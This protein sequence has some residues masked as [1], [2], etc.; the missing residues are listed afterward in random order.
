MDL[1]KNPGTE[2]F[3][4]EMERKIKDLVEEVY[5][6]ATGRTYKVKVANEKMIQAIRG[7]TLMEV[8]D[9]PS[10]RYQWIRAYDAVY[11]GNTFKTVLTNG[12]FMDRALDAGEVAEKVKWQGKPAINKVIS[13]IQD[14]SL[15]NISE[16]LGGGQKVRN[17]Y[18]NILVP[19]SD[20]Y[21][22][23]D[24]HAGAAAHLM[25]FGSE[26]QEIK[27][28][29]DQISLKAGAGI[30]KHHISRAIYPV[31]AEA[32]RLAAEELDMLPRE[33]QSITWEAIRGMF[34]DFLKKERNLEK[35]AL[36][37]E[38][39]KAFRAAQAEIIGYSAK[40]GKLK[41]PLDSGAAIASKGIW[42][43]LK[44]YFI[45]THRGEISDGARAGIKQYSKGYF[46]TRKEGLRSVEQF[47]PPPWLSRDPNSYDEVWVPF[48]ASGVRGVGVGGGDALERS[49]GGDVG[50]RAGRAAGKRGRGVKA[51]AQEGEGI[52]AAVRFLEDGRARIQLMRSAN[53]SSLIHEMAHVFRR[54]LSDMEQETLAKV[55]R[56]E[57]GNWSEEAEEQFARNFERYLFNGGQGFPGKPGELFERMKQTM[58]RVYQDVEKSPIG[59]QVSPEV[60][61]VFGRMF[62]EGYHSAD[63]LLLDGND[64]STRVTWQAGW[65][66][67]GI[68]VSAERVGK[69]LT[70]AEAR[71]L[72]HR[73]GVT[74]KGFTDT[75][76]ALAF[77]RDAHKT[78]GMTDKAY[79][80]DAEEKLLA[81]LK[82]D[83]AV[84][85]GAKLDPM[86][87]AQLKAEARGTA[88]TGWDRVGS[89]ASK[90]LKVAGDNPLT[91]LNRTVGRTLEDVDH[92]ALF[93]HALDEGGKG[94]DPLA[95][96]QLVK[97]YLFDATNLT[98]VEK[99]LMRRVIPFYSWLRFNI[100]L[101]LHAL[102]N[103]PGRYA[104]VPKVINEIQAQSPDWEDLPTPD[105]FDE[106]NAVRL[107]FM[108]DGKPLYLNTGLP[109][110][111]L[112]KV[113][114]PGHAKEAMRDLMSA[115]G[116]AVKGVYGLFSNQD[117]YFNRPIENYPGEVSPDVPALDK[118]TD[119]LLGVAAPAYQRAKGNIKAAERG[120]AGPYFLGQLGIKFIPSDIQRVMRGQTYS[121]L[122][123]AKAMRDKVESQNKRRRE[124]EE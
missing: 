69:P 56:T 112:N 65:K 87:I 47:N 20:R 53:P 80:R 67:L 83:E 62:G 39:Y 7:K 37:A 58:G 75:E 74:G 35:L 81:A 33:L 79:R 85:G 25:P 38:E 8:M 2:R 64:L 119:W 120:E 43:V 34:P 110:L 115:A 70:V 88:A 90:A 30:D 124:E 57:H 86:T 19:N 114:L 104:M 103:D 27:A 9:D 76:T 12:K 54:Q 78:L 94:A 123:I 49:A 113:P 72:M 93:L 42:S 44:P 32:Y 6:E 28:L 121:R 22:T 31:Y 101:Q 116:P 10:A 26:S 89:L 77:E 122:A 15:E 96:A 40:T 109:Y 63:N 52:N 105:Y 48:N 97:R 18:N 3:D 55:Y 11:N 60:Q 13:I 102:F 51:L 71:D 59:G 82:A 41:S 1:L 45:G 91:R 111:D 23:V 17:F 117:P 16:Q 95:A 36:S 24:T 118:Q 5:D 106:I 29:F 4:A 92:M 21:V 100:P 68:P 99:R 46:A 66:K 73:M 84:P 61:K 14:G 50:R 108:R 98:D 107:P